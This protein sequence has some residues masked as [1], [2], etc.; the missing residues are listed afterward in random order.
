MRTILP[1][2]AALIAA[3]LAV[4]GCEASVEVGKGFDR[5]KAEK[6]IRDTVARQVG[7]QVRSV[8]CPSDVKM[9]TGLQITCTV[10]GLDGT[11]GPAYV[12]FKNDEGDVHV[13]A[14]LLHVREAEQAISGQLAGKLGGQVLV[15][16]PEIIRVVK[17]RTF[18]CKA[19]KGKDTAPVQVVLEDA[20][21]H[22]RYRLI[23]PSPAPPA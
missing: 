13:S 19:T 2:G 15:S 8:T 3:A 11:K 21:G 18:R 10:V 4:A 6:T 16:C 1:A 12:R 14:P 7:A 20:A 9:K 17:G 5:A 23:V 22:F